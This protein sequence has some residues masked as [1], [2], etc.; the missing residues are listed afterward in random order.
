M[1]FLWGKA[2][3][4][5]PSGSAMGIIGRVIYIIYEKASLTSGGRK[6]PSLKKGGMRVGERNVELVE[7]MVQHTI[8]DVKELRIDMKDMKKD[9]E[10]LKQNQSITDNNVNQFQMMFSNLTEQI[11]E[12]REE[13]KNG[14]EEDKREKEEELR[15][16]E[17]R[18][19]NDRKQN[20]N[21]L[22]SIGVLIIGTFILVQLGLK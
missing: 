5:R 16:M 13:F 6:I 22:I 18:I 7:Q 4:V 15:N 3:G 1:L 8:D 11:K 17:K 10:Q 19:E 9:F 14:Q 20:R 2:R 21:A 12:L